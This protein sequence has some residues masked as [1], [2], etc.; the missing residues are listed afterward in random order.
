[1]MHTLAPCLLCRRCL[2][3]I[4]IITVFLPSLSAARRPVSPVSVVPAPDEPL[5]KDAPLQRT[6]TLDETGVSLEELLRKVSSKTV[7]LSCARVC[8]PQKVQVRLKQRPLYALMESLAELL[9]GSWKRL[10]DGSGYRLEID[11]K[12]LARRERWWRLFLREREKAKAAQIAYMLAEMRTPPE[13]RRLTSNSPQ[14]SKMATLAR[15]VFYSLP[16]SLQEL[17]ARQ[18]NDVPFYTTGIMLFTS[19]DEEGAILVRLSDLPASAQEIVREQNP[20]LPSDALMRFAN[21][22]FILRADI[23]GTEGQRIGMSLKLDVPFAPN[24]L[25]LLSNH[26]MLVEEVRRLGRDAPEAWKQLAAYEESRV[27]DNTLPENGRRPLQPP[28]RVAILQWL[29]EKAD[30]EFVADYYS[31]PCTP[32]PM[33]PEQRARPLTRPLEAE[34]NHRAA[35][36]DMSWKRRSD[37]IYLFR[38]NRW[39]RDDY[40]EVPAPLLKRWF[41]MHSRDKGSQG[42][43]SLRAN[44]PMRNLMDWSAEVVTTLTPWQIANGLRWAV[45]EERFLVQNTQ[46]PLVNPVSSKLTELPFSW[47]FD[48]DYILRS[49][50]T[51]RFYASLSAPARASLLENHLPFTALNPIQ[52][53]QAL[54][55]LPTLRALLE[56]KKPILLGLT[57]KQTIGSKVR[58]VCVTP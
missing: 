9:P 10:K 29:G 4:T 33:S 49:Y 5:A 42:P 40:L 25:S 34:L 30:M 47:M 22:G 57:L 27:W 20:G 8:A 36:L 55:C 14:S 31:L 44:V 56:A 6:I 2:F 21:G 19:D 18:L 32:V 3:S 39:Y 12:T 54:L 16:A 50:S 7:V 46:K 35:E 37:D 43:L 52:Q 15:E 45:R 28:R 24:A 51:V 41:S 13:K 11:Q 58:L 48:S 1:M 26:A 23:L 17:I 38:N 53:K